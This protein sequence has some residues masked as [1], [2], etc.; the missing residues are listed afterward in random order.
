LQ[1]ITSGEFGPAAF[2]RKEK[3]A[4]GMFFHFFIAVTVA[5]IGD[6]PQTDGLHSSTALYMASAVHL[7][8]RRNVVPLFGALKREFSAKAFLAQLMIHI[9]CVGLPIALIMSY[10]S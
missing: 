3:A 4:L 5:S 2:R 6:P 7:V 8:M 9:Y 10:F 1:T